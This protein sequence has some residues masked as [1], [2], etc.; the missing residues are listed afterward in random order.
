[1]LKGVCERSQAGEGVHAQHVYQP[2]TA[3]S[4]NVSAVNTNPFEY[5]VTHSDPAYNELMT[6]V[7]DLMD[8]P[9]KDILIHQIFTDT[10]YDELVEELDARK[11]GGLD[12]M[13]RHWQADYRQR[14]AVAGFLKDAKLGVKRLVSLPDRVTNCIRLADGGACLRPTVINAYDGPPLSSMATWWLQWREFMFRTSVQ[15]GA[16]SACG[17]AFTRNDANEG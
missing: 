2:I 11:I 13:R 4:W 12:L 8:S 3:A 16:P 15:V 1:M 10:M 6:G 5:W 17:R 9:E 7:Q 14:T